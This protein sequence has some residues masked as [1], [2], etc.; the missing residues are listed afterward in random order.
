MRALR[1]CLLK[2]AAGRAGARLRGAPFAACPAIAGVRASVCTKVILLAAHYIILSVLQLLLLFSR[3]AWGRCAYMQDSPK[4]G[5]DTCI[6]ILVL[7]CIP[8]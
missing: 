3:H 8:C 4:Q 1:V 7:L 5:D 2:R 6:F